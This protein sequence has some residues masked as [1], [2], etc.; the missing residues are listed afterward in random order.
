MQVD[1]WILV[2]YSM[3]LPVFQ[4]IESSVQVIFKCNV[5]SSEYGNTA[6]CDLVTRGQ[7]ADKQQTEMRC[8]VVKV[9][10]ISV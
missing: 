9:S 4:D 7:S 8:I 6:T 1:T 10:A 2:H 5:Y 3:P